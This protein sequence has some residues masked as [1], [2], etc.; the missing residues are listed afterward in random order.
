MVE[1]DAID[2]R[3]VR[4][5]RGVMFCSGLISPLRISASSGSSLSLS[6]TSPCPR[7]LESRVDGRDMRGELRCGRANDGMKSDLAPEQCQ[8]DVRWTERGTA[9]APAPQSKI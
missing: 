4:R 8:L 7:T 9:A 3:E 5:A 2:V 1:A 6:S